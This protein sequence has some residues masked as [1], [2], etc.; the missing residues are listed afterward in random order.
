LARPKEVNVETILV[1]AVDGGLCIYGEEIP[2]G[3]KK[4]LHGTMSQESY[5]NT[6]LVGNL[7]DFPVGNVI[8]LLLHSG[9]S[10]YSS[11]DFKV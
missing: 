6:N 7:W 1:F 9:N 8:F 10:T 2:K 4:M 5:F 11:R 3:L